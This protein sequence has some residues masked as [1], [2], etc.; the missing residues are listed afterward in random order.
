LRS[1]PGVH[2]AVLFEGF[3]GGLDG[4]VDII[5]AHIRGGCPYFSIAWVDDVESLAGLGFDPVASNEG[6]LAEEL[7]V[8]ELS[9]GQP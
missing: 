1:L 2:F 6:L 3:V 4:V 5:W 8:V 9:N 7:W